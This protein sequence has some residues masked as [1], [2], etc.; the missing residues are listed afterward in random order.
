MISLC[1]LIVGASGAEAELQVDHIIPVS[2]GGS[3]HISNLTTACAYCNRVKGAGRLDVVRKNGS[4]GDIL[5]GK[6]AHK[7][8]NGEIE[9]QGHII[10]C[11]GDVFFIERCSFL[12]GLPVDILSITKDELYNL[13]IWTVYAE[14]IRFHLAYYRKMEKDGRLIGNESPLEI[15]ESVMEYKYGPNWWKDI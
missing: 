13:E 8:E 10:G 11:D 3:N 2:K 9:Y 14:E 6:Y 7:F 4:G 15:V 12:D 5:I 1:A